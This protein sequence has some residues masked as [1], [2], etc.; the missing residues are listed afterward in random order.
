[1][2]TKQE[3]IEQYNES[4]IEDIKRDLNFLKE[5]LKDVNNI[6]LKHDTL[7]KLEDTAEWQDFKKMYFEDER[8]RVADALTSEQKF[9]EEAER[10]LHEKLTSIR[11]LKLFLRNIETKAEHNKSF[12]E[13]LKLRIE[14][15]E[16]LLGSKGGE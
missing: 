6:I 5:E 11:H 14:A 2:Q 4:T 8:N 7:L 3:I 12:V 13:E 9:R 10:Q 1:M 15:L 16:E